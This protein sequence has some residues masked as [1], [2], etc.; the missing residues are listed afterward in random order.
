MTLL[1]DYTETK[2]NSQLARQFVHS[3][4]GFWTVPYN[5]SGASGA[6]RGF[7]YNLSNTR[8]F[9]SVKYIIIIYTRKLITGTLFLFNIILKLL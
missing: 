8:E 2:R 1:G 7:S 3:V 4:N 6:W 9:Y 5:Y